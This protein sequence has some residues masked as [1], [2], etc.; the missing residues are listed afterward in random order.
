MI[1]RLLTPESQKDPYSWASAFGAHYW[2]AL[3][4]W[5]VI[6][7]GWTQWTAAWVVPL[8]YLVCWEGLQLYLQKRVTRALVWDS[9][10]DTTGVALACYSAACL[11]NDLKLSA[12]SCWGASL[13]VAA[14]GWRVREARK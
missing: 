8:L 7:I 14:V 12:V 13:I 3:G 10:L 11:G 6:A 2:I 5:G 1:R 9:I 4:P